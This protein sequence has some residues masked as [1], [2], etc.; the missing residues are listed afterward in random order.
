MTEPLRVLSLGWGVQSWTLAAMAA[1]GELDPFDYAIHADTT[2]EAAATYAHAEKWT[3]WLEERGVQ[4]VTVLANRPDVVREDW[5]ASILIPA[6]TIT[7]QPADESP[8]A[9]GER[10]R[11]EYKTGQVKRQCTHDWKIMP[12]RRFIRTKLPRRPSPSSV[13]SIQGIS[14]DEFTRMRDSD[15]QYIEHSYP[16]VDRRMTRADCVQWLQERR[17]DVPVKSACVFCP[18]R[19]L[20]QWKRLKQAGGTDWDKAVAVDTMI[21]YKRQ[22]GAGKPGH[23]VQRG[24]TLYVHPAR[25]PLPEAVVIPE[26]FGAEQM[27]FEMPCDGGTC[28][29]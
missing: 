18:Y 6:F 10:T 11:L 2:H 8:Y 21:R 20:G 12:I 16:L 9:Q 23:E 19:S 4:V 14:L 5:S 3:P 17:L 25:K 22:S 13:I 15:V 27:E 24:I 29:V 1:L 26:D 28:W 7:E